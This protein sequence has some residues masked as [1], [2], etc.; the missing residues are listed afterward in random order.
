MPSGKSSGPDG[1]FAR[2]QD[3]YRYILIWFVTITRNNLFSLLYYYIS[4]I[5]T[6]L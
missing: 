5:F 3:N 4:K 6:S 2:L 1:L